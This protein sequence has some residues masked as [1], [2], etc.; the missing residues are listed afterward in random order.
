M[1]TTLAEAW[2]V[3]SFL[4]WEDRQEGKHEFDG[5][6][7]VAMTGGSIAH[8][9]IVA[10]LIVTLLRLLQPVGLEPFQDM[11]VRCGG[12]VRYSDIAVWSGA[13]DQ[14]TRT[15]TDAVAI[16]EV[17]SDDTATTDR[18]DKLLDYALLPS[19]RIYVLLEQTAMAATLFQREPAGVWI[20]SAHVDGSLVLPGPDIELPLAELYRRLTFP[21]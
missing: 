13:V 4:A 5:R 6:H 16:F 8:Q 20:A 2:T 11:R 21:T 12:R 19:L 1:D 3:D 17:L 18:V 15:L 9:R 14:T 7:A 10:N